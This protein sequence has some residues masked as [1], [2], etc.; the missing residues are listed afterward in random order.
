MGNLRKP[1]RKCTR[2]STRRCRLWWVVA[3][4]ARETISVAGRLYENDR[5]HGNGCVAAVC[6]RT[7]TV[8]STG[9]TD[10]E[11]STTSRRAGKT[12][13]PP[14]RGPKTRTRR[15]GGGGGGDGRS[16]GLFGGGGGAGGRRS[17]G[18]GPDARRPPVRSGSCT[19]PGY[20]GGG[21]WEEVTAGTV[22]RL[23]GDRSR[24]TDRPAA[25]G[26][27][28][29]RRTGRRTRASAGARTNASR[30]A[31]CVHGRSVFSPQH[32]HAYTYKYT[33][34]RRTTYP[35]Q[36][37]YKYIYIILLLRGTMSPCP[38]AKMFHRRT[39]HYLYYH[40]NYL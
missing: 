26:V 25:V 10:R 27:T 33:L 39:A 24:Y 20:S 11:C 37:H 31:S 30:R 9:T 35:N 7:P 19:R 13:P 18:P 40:T 28:K 17:R 12:P 8:R 22:T 1:I 36:T 14:P 38:P 34:Y 4:R 2:I 16:G 21:L 15:C 3:E 29:G 6:A 5:E 23:L 32:V